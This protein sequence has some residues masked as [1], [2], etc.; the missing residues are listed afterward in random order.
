MRPWAIEA[1]HA[2]RSTRAIESTRANLRENP[3]AKP[4]LPK[5]FSA[6]EAFVADRKKQYGCDRTVENKIYTS[7]YLVAH[8][9]RSNDMDALIKQELLLHHIAV[10]L[11]P[12]PSSLDGESLVVCYEDHWWWN[13]VMH[14]RSLH[15]QLYD[16]ESGVS[17]V[18]TSLEYPSVP[19]SS[20]A[21][22]KQAIDDLFVKLKKATARTGWEHVT[23][24]IHSWK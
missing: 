13:L 3:T 12:E 10:S 8:G 9:G 23:A 11:G 1:L 6:Y 2:R 17:I 19:L 7:A 22:V 21:A 20:A 16:G 18:M 14:L 24:N 5:G 15:I 4:A